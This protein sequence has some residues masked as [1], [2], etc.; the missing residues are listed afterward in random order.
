[1]SLLLLRH[2][3]AGQRQGWTG[4]DR[5]RPLT[6][7]GERQAAALADVL[8]GEAPARIFTSAYRRCVDTVRPLA[9]RCGLAVTGVD[10]LGADVL[11]RPDAAG[12]VVRGLRCLG[13]ASERPVVVCTHGEVM[14]MALPAV[15]PGPVLHEARRAGAPEP[16]GEKG[17]IWVLRWVDGTVAE[18]AFWPPPPP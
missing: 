18:V 7:A 2:A 13:E 11:E 10:W 5:E 3:V 4:D 15:V 17:G 12:Q 14:A 6:E 9:D 8:A 16:P 1:V